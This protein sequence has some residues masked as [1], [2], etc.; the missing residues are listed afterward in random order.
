LEING[1][2]RPGVKTFPATELIS[3]AEPVLPRETH[4]GRVY[5]AVQFLDRDL[6][7]RNLYPLIFLGHDLD[8]GSGNLRYFQYFDSYIA[9][10]RYDQ[11]TKKLSVLRGLRT[12]GGQAYLR[13]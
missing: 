9:G 4:E 2:F 8:S 5:F 3:Y 6:L 10:V 12:R 1:K 13:V 7:V 11:T